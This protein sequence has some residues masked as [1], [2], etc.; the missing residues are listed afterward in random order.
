[1]GL[2]VALGATGCG[3]GGAGRPGDLKIGLITART[4][5]AAFAG[6]SFAQGAELARDELNRAGALG[7]DRDVVLVEKEGAEN[8]AKSVTQMR[9]FVADDRIQATTGAI[10]SPVAGALAPVARR[11]EL[12]FVIYGATEDGLTDPPYVYRTATLPQTANARL[13]RTVAREVRPRTVTYVVTQDNSGMQSQLAAFQREFDAAGVRSLG[14][15]NTLAQQRNFGGAATDAIARGADVIVVSCLQQ[16]ELAMIRELRSRG[17]RGLIVANETIATQGAFE[18]VGAPLADAPFP[19][20]FSPASTTPAAQ[21]FARAYRGRYGAAPDSYAAQGYTAVQVLAAAGRDAGPELTR[22]TVT[23]AL[24]RLRE[25]D[26]TV[27]GTVTFRGG[28]LHAD[29]ALQEIAW[30]ARGRVRP[31]TPTE[32]R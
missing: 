15:V 11:A 4:G 26:G 17:Y 28:Q 19:V 22:A 18:A 12:P 21:R 27:Y 30:N 25:L 1:A 7:G 14:T 10:L 24:G 8:P 29:D 31:W 16:P 23:A 13:G 2:A 32:T 5:P 9:Q 6:V 20:Y 3:A